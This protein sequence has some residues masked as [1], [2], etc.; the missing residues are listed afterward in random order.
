MPPMLEIL[1]LGIQGALLKNIFKK[2][3]LSLAIVSALGLSISAASA[4][5]SEKEKPKANTAA[6]LLKT[7]LSRA[8]LQEE[9]E[10]EKIKELKGLNGGVF[11]APYVHK[12]LKSILAKFV[13]T[14]MV[15]SND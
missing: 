9:L 8:K 11:Q 12:N 7:K 14:G 4:Q 1:H 2:F 15:D 3:I 5:D 10:K 13:K 6:D